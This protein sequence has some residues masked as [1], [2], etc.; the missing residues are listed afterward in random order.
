MWPLLENIGQLPRVS[1]E[2]Y[3]IDLTLTLKLKYLVLIWI[4]R[5]LTQMFIKRIIASEGKTR[6]HDVL[7]CR[8]DYSTYQLLG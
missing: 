6:L 8:G 3:G 2:A 5:N 1:R 7:R 4:Y